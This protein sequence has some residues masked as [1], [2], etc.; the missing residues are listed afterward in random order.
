MRH[1]SVPAWG[2]PWSATG[3]PSFGIASDSPPQGKGSADLGRE[4]PSRIARRKRGPLRTAPGAA[5]NDVA[6]D[7]GDR[8]ALR[9]AR[10]A[11]GGGCRHEAALLGALAR[12]AGLL[13][14]LD[15][16]AERRGLPR[17]SLLLAGARVALAA[18]RAGCTHVHAHFAHAAAATAIMSARLGGL[19]IALIGH[20]SDIYGTPR[21]LPAKLRAADLALATCG[22]MQA[23]LRTIMPAARVA[24]L[25]C[26][27]DPSR[28]QPADA[29]SNGR[30]LAVGRLAPQKGY[31]AQLAALPPA[32]RPVT[33]VVGEGALRPPLEARIAAEG[34][35]PWCNLPWPVIALAIRLDS[36]GPA[37]FRQRRIGRSMHGRTEIFEMAKFRSMRQD[38]EAKSGAVWAARN[39][40]R[41]TQVGLFLRKTRLDELPQPINVLRG[42]MAIVGPRPERPDLQAAMRT[43]AAMAGGEGR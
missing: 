14:A 1:S 23:D 19:T 38:A 28:F 2:R 3:D 13:G 35:A 22:D 30:P 21:E 26:G 33:D 4:A 29:P 16:L 41:I 8:H 27:I 17:R 37:I 20:G 5:I 6:T 42:D 25:R 32:Q 9:P 36:P 43:L 15:F 40:P 18:R 31:E 10:A 12:P 34:L 24:V 7:C 11:R 39:D